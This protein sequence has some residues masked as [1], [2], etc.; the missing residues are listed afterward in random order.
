MNADEYFK[1]LILTFPIL[2]D[3]IEEENSDMI[4]MRMEVLSDY[5]IDEIKNKDWNELKRC[6]DFQ[7]LRIEKAS[8]ELRN[9]LTVS[10]CESLLLGEIAG[11]MKEIV[12][13]MGTKLKTLYREYED[14]YNDLAKRSVNN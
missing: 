6:F 1:D 7:E 9:A 11:Q 12:P 8:D 10:Y 13:R 3:K 14:Y 2:K 4:H 5:T